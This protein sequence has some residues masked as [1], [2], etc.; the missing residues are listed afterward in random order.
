[1][2]ITPC[3][4]RG[5]S[6][7]ADPDAMEFGGD[8]SCYLV[9]GA[10][11]VLIT[12]DA[13]SGTRSL[14]AILRERDGDR[15]MLLLMT[16]YHLDHVIGFPLLSVLYGSAWEVTIAAPEGDGFRVDEVMPRVMARPFWPVRFESLRAAIRFATLAPSPGESGHTVGGVTCRWCPVHH[17]GGCSAYRLD[18]PA[19]GASAVI[20]TDIEW[21]ESTPQEKEDFI[22]FCAMPR[23][24][25]A[26]IFDGHFTPANYERH[27]GWGHSRWTDGVEAARQS[28]IERLLITHHSP[29]ADDA[30]L[31][32]VE[33][34]LRAVMPTA[35]LLRQ[36]APIGFPS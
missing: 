18:E 14:N 7:A 15:S 13:G 35:A 32:N 28:G 27:R 4:I 9:E 11:G 1:M 23:P 5:T 16:H 17:P 34:D 8:T 22:R 31:R 10:G 2:K 26:L 6:V 24:A 20:A 12:V 29:E 33:A 19:T 3:G 30:R 25:D 21:D 36:G